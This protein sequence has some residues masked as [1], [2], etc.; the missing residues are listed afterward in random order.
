M[1]HWQ[2]MND[3]KKFK[4][5]SIKEIL[6]QGK[7]KRFK[8]ITQKWMQESVKNKYSY[9]FEWLGRPI[10]QYPQDIIAVQNLLWKIKPDLVIETGIARGGSLIFISSILELI[11]QCGE[12]KKSKVVGIDI[13]IRKHNKIAIKKH[14]MS[15]RIITIEGSSTDEKIFR[16]VRSISKRF[17]K[18]MLFLDSN[19]AH[20]HVLK[21]LKLYAPLVSKKSYCI[22]FDTI[23]NYLPNKFH[24]NKPWNKKHNPKT[25]VNN[26]LRYLKSK[27][28]RDYKNNLIKFENNKNIENQLLITV[29]PGGFLIR[30]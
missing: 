21:E 12:S 17:K 24:L 18:I 30:R 13:D 14:P 4:R 7:N 11:A 3:H 22:V 10:I 6:N 19:H 25:A 28:P 1:I 20:E 27:K 8:L 9:H 2:I 29:A 26:Y 5:Q 16:K 23:I 15:K